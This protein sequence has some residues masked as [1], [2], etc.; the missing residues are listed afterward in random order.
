MASG[1]LMYHRV[2]S[3]THDPWDLCVTPEH[4]AQQ[5]EVLQ[6]R[7]HCVP[8]TDL[9]RRSR[10]WP[11][12]VRLAITFDDGYRD[13]LLSALPILERFQLPATVFVVSGSIGSGREFWWDTLE[14]CLLRPERLPAT[15]ELTVA[16]GTRSWSVE[17][18]TSGN[19]AGWRAAQSDVCTPRQRLFVAIWQLLLGLG[20]EE[21]DRVLSDLA[22][23]SGVSLLAPPERLPMTLEEL[24][25]LARHPL[26]EIGAH[27]RGHPPLPNLSPATQREEIAASRDELQC[28]VGDRVT[29]FSYPY[30]RHDRTS[31]AIV[32][33]LGFELACT[34]RSAPMTAA[35]GRWTLPRL[36]V[37][38]QSGPAFSSWLNH[39][40]PSLARQAAR[41]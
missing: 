16:A 11:R 18:D 37:T 39:F 29:T 4:F 22:R 20:S 15:L 19:S 17:P 2:A 40:F 6:G 1:I 30:G 38:D 31:A 26:I 35:A 7:V 23:W 41:A 32:R 36:Q 9:A 13:N 8:L 28:M 12:R 25:Q 5:L 14:R 10:Q 34:S 27:T 33:E 3:E 24:R 21:R